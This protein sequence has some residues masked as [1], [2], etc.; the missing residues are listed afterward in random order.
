MRL[1]SEK[2]GLGSEFRR[3]D[4]TRASVVLARYHASYTVRQISGFAFCLFPLLELR[5][6]GLSFD[7]RLH[8]RVTSP[9]LY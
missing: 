3:Y 6:F 1:G 2:G 9:K 5:P 4:E 8:L 7:R